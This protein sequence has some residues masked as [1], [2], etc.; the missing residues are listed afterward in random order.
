MEKLDS[1]LANVEEVMR[2][3]ARRLRKTVVADTGPKCKKAGPGLPRSVVLP[4]SAAVGGAPFYFLRT[5]DET[6]RKTVSEV[7]AELGVTLAA[8]TV[9]ANKLAR[10]GWVNRYRDERDRRVVWLELT[11]SGR[12]VL[13]RARAARKE[14]F[15]RYFSGFSAEEI[16][17]L[18]RIMGT[19][20]A[21]LR[22]EE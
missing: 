10:S 13:A 12:E 20:L 9:L 15:A 21:K 16:E 17:T 7:A 4:L 1:C 19:V 18:E 11:P 22:E 14:I 6:V 8:V 5:L 2:L 3:F